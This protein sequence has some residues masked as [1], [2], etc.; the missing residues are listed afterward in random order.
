[1]EIES[2]LQD[3]GPSKREKIEAEFKQK[4]DSLVSEI[5]RTAPNLKA[6]GQ[7]EALQEKEKEV[8]EEFEAA[9]REEKEI[10][11]KYNSIKQRRL[12]F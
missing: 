6:L 10:A 4:M 3:Q 12:Y 7:Y 1:M 2:H 9:R 5:E 11:D 8:V